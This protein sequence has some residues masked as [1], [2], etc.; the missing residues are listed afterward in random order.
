[1]KKLKTLLGLANDQRQNIVRHLRKQGLKFRLA[2]EKT[3]AE[4]AAF[5]NRLQN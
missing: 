5:Y 4:A 2:K 1:L 3:I